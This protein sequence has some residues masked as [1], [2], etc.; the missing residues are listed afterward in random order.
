MV[1]EGQTKVDGLIDEFHFSVYDNDWHHVR[2][3]SP[4]WSGKVS[5]Y[6]GEIFVNAGN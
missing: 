3:P 6:P 5:V 2:H 1:K 4:L